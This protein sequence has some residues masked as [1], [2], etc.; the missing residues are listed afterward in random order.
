M[1]STRTTDEVKTLARRLYETNKFLIG[2]KNNNKLSKEKIYK[3]YIQSIDISLIQETESGRKIIKLTRKTT[4]HQKK[5]NLNL[6]QSKK[7]QDEKTI[8]E[9]IFRRLGFQCFYKRP[10]ESLEVLSKPKI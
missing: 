8:V 6:H 2:Q 7:L 10:K 4:R 9:I 1:K 5:K 3:T